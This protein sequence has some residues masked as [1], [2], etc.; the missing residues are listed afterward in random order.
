M[1]QPPS[2]TGVSDWFAAIGSNLTATLSL[3]SDITV[4][5][6]SA[7]FQ[8]NQ[9]EPSSKSVLNWSSDVETTGGQAYTV[10]PGSLLSPVQS[11]A[12]TFGSQASPT[13][14]SLTLS[15][16]GAQF[17][18]DNVVSGSANFA[19]SKLTVNVSFT[20]SSSSV[21]LTGATLYQVALSNL[22]INAGGGGFG[23]TVGGNGDIGVAAILPAGSGDS[24]YWV[25][26]DSIGLGGSLNLGTGI[27]ATVTSVSV[28]LN[29]AGGTG[30]SN[31]AATPLDWTND[32]D[33][34]QNG[35]YGKPADQVNPGA[36]LSPSVDLTITYTG[37]ELAVSGSLTSLNIFNII[38]G[39]ANFAL[40]QSTVNVA[41]NGTGPADLT[42]A[43][44]IQIGLSGLNA[45]AGTGG[46][47][48]AVTGGDLGIAV[49]EPSDPGVDGRH[50]VAV[51]GTGLSASLNLGSSISATLAS[52][53]VQI[54]Q[55]GGTGPDHAPATA[56]NWAAD[57]ELSGATTFGGTVNPGSLLPKPPA[58]PD[59]TIAFTGPQLA[60]SGSLTNLNIFNVITGSAD[61]AISQTTVNASLG[62]NTTLT[63]ATLIQVAL[64][65][66]QA[67]AGAGG[68]GVA[69]T[70][71]TLGLAVLQATGTNDSRYWIGVTGS[72]LA[73]NL[74]LTSSI[75]AAV[76]NLSIAIN[77]AG[78]KDSGG[79]AA[80]ALDWATAFPTPVDSAPTCRPRSRCRSPSPPNSSP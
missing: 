47:G 56:L 15:G 71:G 49:L 27:S 19:I 46:F 13:G 41:F 23:L 53:S 67:G 77:Q 44:L 22:T 11:L 54:N 60:V 73:A 37:Q 75:T 40:S 36:G 62:G 14:P 42:G 63:G 79:N 18:I 21:D 16:T 78:G 50:W 65:N 52:V 58:Q 28:M 51:Y 38:T 25:A 39:S 31:I 48:V 29:L 35:Q 43:T 10:D 72:G 80:T 17:N 30:P 68:F 69:V 74:S 59:L 6:G 57:L 33:L 45:T 61:F 20:G 12:I 64:N 66:L 7:S 5:T 8:I 3:G 26:V 76:A 32:L 70:G 9:V 2:S 4:S 34:Q 1:I 55:A 24:R